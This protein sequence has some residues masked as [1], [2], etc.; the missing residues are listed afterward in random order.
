MFMTPAGYNETTPNTTTDTNDSDADPTTG[1]SPV[2][3]LVSGE[4][5]QTVDAGIYK[6]ATIGDYVWRDTDGDGIQDPTELGIN[7]VTVLLKDAT[8]LAVLQTTVTT[9]GGPTGSAGYYNFT[10][11]PGT[12]VVMFMAPTGNTLSPTGNGTTTTDSDPNPT[13]GNS[14]PVTV[15]SGGSNQTIDA[16]LYQP[17]SLG[18]YVWEDLNKNGIQEAGEP[19][20]NGVTVL[21]KNANGTVLQSTVTA[22]NAGTAGYY[23]FTNLAPGDYIVMFMTP[24]GYNETTPNT[25]TDANDSD[26]DPATGN[27]PLTNL[28]SGES[29]Q[30]IDAGIYRPATIGDYV[31]RDTDGDG[32]QDPTELGING[33]TVLLK[34]AT[35]LAVLQTT[36]TT[37]G[38]PTGGAGYYS[39]TADPGT[40]V[41]MFMAPTGNTLSP[42]GN[43]TTTTDSDP[44]PT[45]GNSNPVTVTSGGSNQTID[46]GLYQPASLGN[47]VWEDLNK[48]GIQEAGEPGVNGVTVLLKNAGGIVLQTTVTTTNAGT[49]GYYQFTNQ[50]QAII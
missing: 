5:D 29:D 39:F 41:V 4:S 35:T 26:A 45:T 48:N 19:G 47:Y 24:T 25:T 32:I 50:L 27:S 2:T 38:G 17:A 23:Q 22:T 46:A 43:G 33:V 36:V 7:G 20:V 14:N 8:T 42:T 1:N 6:P 31:W 9:N 37:N 28:V 44:N 12:Y 16:G 13:T 10:V 11:D 49:A 3:N 30:T 21:L 34:D 40:Y 18:N 15:T